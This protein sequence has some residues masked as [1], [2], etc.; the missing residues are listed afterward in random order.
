MIQTR[1]VP[2]KDGI[3][4]LVFDQK[5]ATFNT[6]DIPSHMPQDHTIEN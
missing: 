5:E 4:D 3:I 2:I 6:S 1:L